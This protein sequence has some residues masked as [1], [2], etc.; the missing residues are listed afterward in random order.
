MVLQS[1]TPRDLVSA[2]QA[3]FTVEERYCSSISQLKNFHLRELSSF[4][5]CCGNRDGLA[6]HGICCSVCYTWRHLQ[7]TDL[8]SKLANLQ[9]ICSDCQKNKLCM[10]HKPGGIKH[11]RGDMI[12]RTEEK[13]PRQDYEVIVDNNRKTLRL[14]WHSFRAKDKGYGI[15]GI[16]FSGTASGLAYDLEE[17]AVFE[18]YDR[19]T[20]ALNP[21]LPP[22]P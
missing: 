16:L 14:Q 11:I 8:V 17:A 21:P 20:A 13:Y 6:S 18:D 1:L 22:Y 10:T 12:Y 4:I 9:Y 7:C 19:R 3:S 15:Y 5:P 2:S